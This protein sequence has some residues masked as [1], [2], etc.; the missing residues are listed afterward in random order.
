MDLVEVRILQLPVALHG[1]AAAHNDE[2]QR[3]FTWIAAEPGDV[4]A[5]LV[6]VA[7]AVS[8][9][10][11][12]FTAAQRQ[13]LEDAIAGGLPSVD[14]HYRVPAEAAEAARELG[15]MLD[16]ADRFCEAGGMLTLATTPDLVAYRHWLLGEFE[17][18][19][20]GGPATPWPEWSAAHPVDV[21]GQPTGAA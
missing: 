20:A 3:E 19:C 5:R 2:L 17:R 16:E 9:R 7:R 18:Q 6:T 11:A 4:P 8:E 10:Y 14:L 1:R 13:E 15:A 12:G 21:P